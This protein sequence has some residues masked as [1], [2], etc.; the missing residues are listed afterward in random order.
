MAGDMG[1]LLIVGVII[2]G[3]IWMIQNGGGLGNL[4]P[5]L[6]GGEAAP[7]IEEEAP[8]E[9]VPE[10]EP[11]PEPT[12]PE[13][14]QIPVPYPYPVPTPTPGLTRRQICSQYYGGTCN[15]ECSQ[16]GYSSEICQQCTSYCGPPR[17]DAP[18]PIPRRRSRPEPRP[19]SCPPGQ[20][21]NQNDGKCVRIYG[22]P[23]PKPR[24]ECPRGQRFDWTKKRCMP[25]PPPPNGTPRPKP[26]P[27]PTPS[28]TP[29]P[30]EATDTA[31][32]S[33]SYGYSYYSGWY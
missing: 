26:T 7:P 11:E 21:W 32:A 31:P 19:R 10:E 16:Y 30:V 29:S 12:E 17:Y 24:D 8:P 22:G 27:T 13:I 2:L 9:D 1:S 6:G 28:P 20:R 3:G 4:F 15:T 33:T 25:V 14:Q 23:G 5:Q 18:I